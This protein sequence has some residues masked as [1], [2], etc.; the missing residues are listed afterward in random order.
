SSSTP[1]CTPTW[2][3]TFAP[4]GDVDGNVFASAVFD[5]GRGAG[6]ELYIGGTFTHAGGKETSCIA[7]WDG[8]DWAAVGGGV[9]QE[10]N[11]LLVDTVGGQRALY[12]AGGF[13]TAGGIPALGIA[14][15]D[16]V[17]WT[18][19]GSG[20]AGVRCLATFDDGSGNGQELYAGGGATGLQKWNGASWV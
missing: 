12:V 10:V 2:I 16:G 18:A 4:R 11:C 3:P 8:E 20:V 5:D 14:R 19:L 17:S 15:W 1:N 9:D 7:R 13:T 6:P